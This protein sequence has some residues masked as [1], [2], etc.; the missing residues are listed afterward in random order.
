MAALVLS[1]AGAAAGGA[2]FGPAGAIAGRLVGAIGGN[3]IDRALFGGS[4]RQL[5]GPR[6]ADLDV[7]ASTEGAPIPRVYGRA[8]LAGQVIWAT[9]LEEAVSAQSDTDG[10]GKGS[11]QATTTPRP[12]ATSPTSR[13]A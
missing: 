13:W 2:V 7:M 1:V 10:G 5:E 6:L 11:P 4:E 12:T 8:R 9:K 3:L